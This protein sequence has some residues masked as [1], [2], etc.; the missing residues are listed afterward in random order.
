M[1]VVGLIGFSH[2]IRSKHGKKGNS[3]EVVL[4]YKKPNNCIIAPSAMRRLHGFCRDCTSH[5]I[6]EM[7]VMCA[8]YHRVDL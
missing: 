2:H 6:V 4:N 3:H 5:K 8:H 1:N 7:G